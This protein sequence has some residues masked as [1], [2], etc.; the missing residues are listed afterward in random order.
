MTEQVIEEDF[1]SKVG[2]FIR[3]YYKDILEKVWQLIGFFGVPYALFYLTNSY[4]YE[5]KE[6]KEFLN[7]QKCLINYLFFALFLWTLFL[8]IGRFRVAAIIETVFFMAFGLADYYVFN[9]RGNPI[10]PWDI[11]SIKV[12]SSVADNYSY[13]LESYVWNILIGFVALIILEFFCEIK[14]KKG[15][16]AYSIRV[17]G[18]VACIF[19][20]YGL[21]IYL[22]DED[23]MY[24]IEM[25]PF[26]FQQDVMTK[27]NGLMLTFMYDFNFVKVKKPSGYSDDKAKKYLAEYEDK[28][29]KETKK[30]DVIVIMDEAFADM[31]VIGN[32]ETNTDYMPFIRKLM[33]GYDNTVSG[34]LN[35]SIVGGNTPNSEYEFLTGDT[36][37]FLPMGSVP[38]QQ[39]MFGERD[40]LVSQLK[41]LG[42]HTTAMHPYYQKG[43]NRYNVY[44]Y[45]GF[46]DKYFKDT[47]VLGGKTIRSYYSDESIVDWIID[48]TERASDDP[49]FIFSVTMQNHSGFTENF[50][51]LPH[52][53]SVKGLEKNDAVSNY[54]SLV[55]L[56]DKAVEKL[57]NHYKEA[58]RDTVIVFFGDHQ[59][60]TTIGNPILRM[61]GMDP[62]NLSKEDNAL[63][64]KVPYFI[65]ANYDIEEEVGKEI[66]ANYLSGLMT[67]KVGLSQTPYQLF[68]KDL[69]EEYPVISAVRTCDSKYLPVENE[70]D[71]EDINKYNIIQYYKMFRQK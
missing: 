46:D 27:R 38:Y 8:V 44:D 43:W 71:E 20:I 5:Y 33:Y 21:V 14:L 62:E 13:K 53:V 55:K 51:N 28:A 59:P 24:D 10:L 15:L 63:R 18:V 35:M 11:N 48:K 25:Y 22:N 45:F 54:F 47:S 57:I 49:Q 1:L 36:L 9:F 31:S 66:S 56:T 29:V 65:W 69:R 26:V 34:Y 16:Y 4:L 30:P 7:W 64:Y 70:D 37:K 42:Y 23:H 50:D 12:A 2:G 61:H 40:S 6:V 39:Y 3:K 19:S 68:L 67:E 58:D 60:N 32:I 17:I 41:D 52:T